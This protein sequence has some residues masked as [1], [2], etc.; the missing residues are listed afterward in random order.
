MIL[1]KRVRT[2][3]FIFDLDLE[4]WSV[5]SKQLFECLF[6]R[7]YKRGNRTRDWDEWLVY[8]DPDLGEDD[9]H[10]KIP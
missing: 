2:C 9:H 8:Y 1:D 5:L 6:G 4:E 7:F 3:R 10:Y